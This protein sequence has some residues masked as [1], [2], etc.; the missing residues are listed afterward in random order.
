M[1]L[2]NLIFQ[3]VKSISKG[4]ALTVR[5]TPFLQVDKNYLCFDITDED[6]RKMSPQGRIGLTRWLRE[7]RFTTCTC[8]RLMDRIVN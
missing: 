1:L 5:Y 8:A 4:E 7:E 3:A 6:N 2:T